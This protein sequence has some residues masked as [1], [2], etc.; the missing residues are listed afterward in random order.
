MDAFIKKEEKMTDN[1]TQNSGIPAALLNRDYTMLVDRS[2]SMSNTGTKSASRWKEAEEGAIA[3]S[4]KM[5]EF[6]PDGI[7]LYT[8]ANHF[9]R[10]D[11]VGPDEVI[12]I[13]AK[14]EPNGGTNLSDCL[15]D[16]IEN[17]FSRK[18]SGKSQP[19]G[20]S[21]FIVTDGLPDDESSV[22]R[23]ITKAAARLDKSSEMSMTFIQ[24]GNDPHAR[25]YLKRLDDDLEKEGAKYDIVDTI[26]VDD[27]G[28]KSLAQAL[29]DA[30]TEHK[31]H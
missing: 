21:F 14:E 18:K 27:L 23:V 2:G 28:S 30:I 13:F 11:N 20:E 31:Q 6:D 9:K 29:I 1:L 3:L 26:T 22:A 16:A 25:D 15:S 7:T 12:K 17:Y 4:R 10:Q 24:V 19:N 5:N 8:F